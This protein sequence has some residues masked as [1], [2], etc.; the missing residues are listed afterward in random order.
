MKWIGCVRCEKLGRTLFSEFVR[1]WHQF[2]QFCVDF[3]VGTK[4][5]ETPQNMSCGSN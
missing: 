1:Y 3:R 5:S 4:W 2:G